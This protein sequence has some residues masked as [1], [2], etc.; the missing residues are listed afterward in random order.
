M[1]FL[2]K[3]FLCAIFREAFLTVVFRALFFAVACLAI[4]SPALVGREIIRSRLDSRAGRRLS[5]L[6]AAL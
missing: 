3:V 5:V 1:A 4:V 6:G 2:I